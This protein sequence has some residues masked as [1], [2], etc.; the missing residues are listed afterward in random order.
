MN[1]LHHANKYPEPFQSVLRATQRHRPAEV[2]N[3]RR[4]QLCLESV[5]CLRKFLQL[6]SRWIHHRPGRTWNFLRNVSKTRLE[7]QQ[8]FLR[9]DNC[10]CQHRLRF[11][12]QNYCRKLCFIN[13]K[14]QQQQPRLVTRL[15]FFEPSNMSSIHVRFLLA[16]LFM[17]GP[18]IP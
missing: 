7:R 12:T 8:Y 17:F 11:C 10:W 16:N 6:I 1:A 4:N 5:I 2:I 3:T 14:Q 13:I 18:N 9:E 15:F